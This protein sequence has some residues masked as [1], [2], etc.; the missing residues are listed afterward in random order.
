VADPLLKREGNL[1]FAGLASA[2][3]PLDPM[4]LVA[5][6]RGRLAGYEVVP[7]GPATLLFSV[8][9]EESAPAQ[10]SCQVGVAITGLPKP[11]AGVQIEDYRGL[12][13]LSLPHSGPIR[14]LPATVRRLS[15]HGKGLGYR[16]RPYWRLALRR[17][18]L[19]DGNLLPVADVAVFL[20]Q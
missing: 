2:G 11:I 16:L 15:T 19:A 5:E 9:P 17:R 4:A 18:A 1:R 8:P 6:L 12:Y 3:Y 7:Y 20:D 10:W 14:D 13:A